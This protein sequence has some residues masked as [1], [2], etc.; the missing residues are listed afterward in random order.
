MFIFSVQVFLENLQMKFLCIRKTI[1]LQAVPRISVLIKIPSK[2]CLLE[3][4]KTKTTEEKKAK[5]SIKLH[6]GDEGRAFI[7]KGSTPIC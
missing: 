3:G 5:K 2:F 1:L 6:I 7:R 4:R